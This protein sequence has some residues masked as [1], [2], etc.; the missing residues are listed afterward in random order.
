MADYLSLEDAAKKLGIPTERL[1]E[2]RSQGEVRGFRDGA[3]AGSF[4]KMKLNVW[5]MIYLI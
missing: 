1:V 2:L 5:P 4:P 3:Q